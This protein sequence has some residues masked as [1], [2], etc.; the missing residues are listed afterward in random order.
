MRTAFSLVLFCAT[1]G[2]S[3]GQTQPVPGPILRGTINVVLA[4]DEGIVVL[5]DS[6]LSAVS[7]DE[8]GVKTYHQIA[9]PGRKLFQIDDRTVCTFAGFASAGT[10]SV[11]DFLNSSPAIIG[12][13]QDRLKNF[14]PMSVLDKLR[15]L[16]IIFGYYL[17]A[18]ATLRSDRN[19]DNYIL[20]M[21]I[22]GYDP[23]G[24]AEMGRLVMELNESQGVA[25]PVLLPVT[26]E[27]AVTPIHATSPPLFAG[28]DEVARNIADQPNSARWS[29]DPAVAAYAE[30]KKSRKPLTIQQMKALA[31]SFKRHTAAK[32]PE[33][34]GPDQIAVLTDGRV[35]SFE[36]PRGLP[37]APIT[38]FRFEIVSGLRMNGHPEDPVKRSGTY[39]VSVMGC[40]PIYFNNSFT[41]VHQDVD[42]GYYSTNVFNQSLLSYNGG[43]LNF[44]KSNEVNESDLQIGPNVPRD[45]PEA[46]QLV[47]DFNWHSVEFLKEEKKPPF[48][49]TGEIFDC[50]GGG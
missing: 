12:R 14:S 9:D 7:V 3:L 44:G 10:P 8:H 24:T 48:S 41:G 40:F 47:R 16:N 49:F 27:L 42:D 39:G 43:P 36:A 45:S 17:P 30:A 31:I 13:F 37:P 15:L 19:K 50:R 28:I 33:V 1:V 2:H 21:L 35:Q 38:H 4:D 46:K 6:M 5:T 22:A 32:Y 34:G 11:P 29:G 18:V 26:R 20:E 25:G 23:D